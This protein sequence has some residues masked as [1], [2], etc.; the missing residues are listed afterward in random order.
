MKPR[1]PREK[2]QDPAFTVV[3][4]WERPKLGLC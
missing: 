3:W 1:M 4:V 2:A